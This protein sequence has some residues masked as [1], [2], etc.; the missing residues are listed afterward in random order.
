MKSDQVAQ[1]KVS[2]GEPSF[3]GSDVIAKQ[4]KLHAALSGD[5]DERLDQA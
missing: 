5:N 3:D 2:S 1:S 4:M